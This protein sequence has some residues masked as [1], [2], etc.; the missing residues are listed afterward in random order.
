MASPTYSYALPPTRPGGAA[1]RAGVEAA[2]PPQ[3]R[4]LVVHEGHLNYVKELG[5]A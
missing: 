3:E 5:P 4:H 1:W 2:R